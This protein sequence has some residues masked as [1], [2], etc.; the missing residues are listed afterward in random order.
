MTETSSTH[1]EQEPQ[2]P[3]IGAFAELAWAQYCA[4]RAGKTDGEAR[5]RWQAAAGNQEAVLGRISQ[6]A[7]GLF[8]GT[9]KASAVP[10][11]WK[12]F[13]E[14]VAREY[15]ERPRRN[16]LLGQ[17]VGGTR[18]R[19][20]S[21]AGATVDLSRVDARI[22]KDKRELVARAGRYYVSAIAP[23]IRTEAAP[24]EDAHHSNG[25]ANGTH[26]PGTNGKNGKGPS[27][28]LNGSNGASK[29]P[30]ERHGDAN[31]SLDIDA[32]NELRQ[33]RVK[34]DKL[35]KAYRKLRGTGVT[36]NNNFGTNFE[37][38]RAG[39]LLD[40]EEKNLDRAEER[41]KEEP[42]ED[43]PP[44]ISE[45]LRDNKLGEIAEMLSRMSTNTATP[46]STEMTE[47][48][49]ELAKVKKDAEDSMKTMKEQLDAQIQARNA[50]KKTYDEKIDAV[51]KNFGEQLKKASEKKEEPKTKEDKSKKVVKSGGVAPGTYKGTKMKDLFKSADSHVA[52]HLK[53]FAGYEEEEPKKEI[54]PSPQ[55]E[56]KKEEKPAEPPKDA[57]P[58][59]KAA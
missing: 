20:T 2:S 21:T 18:N 35:L 24:A 33:L 32:H 17:I 13:A 51:T 31:D 45:A 59:E 14:A 8:L 44:E 56:A 58:K 47:L 16:E 52:A 42:I 49:A 36:V 57:K 46:N 34:Y 11:A 43:F 55:L 10:D 37:A 54:A 48:R 15:H 12:A 30:D 1:R 39:K 5:E 25:H 6:N 19:V 38:A 41:L 26:K 28:S 50:D 40:E 9:L 3:L 27:A 29:A 4:I 7:D 23:Q 53:L 22:E